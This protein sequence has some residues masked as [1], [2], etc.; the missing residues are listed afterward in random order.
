LTN[1]NP[2]EA[3]SAAI[4]ECGR[5]RANQDAVLVATLVDGAE[6]AVVADGMGGHAGGE[7]ASRVALDAIRAALDAGADLPAAIQSANGAILSEAG[8]QP[9]LT[10]MGT[11]VVAILRRGDS[12]VVA[13]VGDSRAYRIDADGITQLTHDHSFIAEA[14]RSG[15]LSEQEA[16]RSQWRNAVTRAVGTDS[17]VEVDVFGPFRADAS[18]LVLLCT[19]GLYRSISDDDLRAAIL[20]APDPARAAQRLALS[21]YD[22]G[23]DDN[24]SL[25]VLGFDGRQAPDGPGTGPPTAAPGTTAPPLTGPRQT[26]AAVPAAAGPE[27]STSPRA[28]SDFEPRRK[29]K[30]SGRWTMREAA[31][32]FG[33]IVLVILYVVLLRSVF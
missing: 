27:S 11:T 29:L 14:V 2:L 4:S 23:S 6:L 33:G 9:E 24:I 19:D 25:I 17:A 31:I 10:G 15:H 12:Y 26:V 18:H 20:S 1:G 5:R 32:I 7:V 28:P 16:V 8:A 3:R 30:R 21:A 13:N 22:A